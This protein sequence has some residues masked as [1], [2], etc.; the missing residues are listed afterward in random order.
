M[1]APDGP[2]MPV[3]WSSWTWNE[4]SV[5]DDVVPVAGGDGVEPDQLGADSRAGHAG[6]SGHWGYVAW[7]G[8][9][10][11]T[12]MASMVV[13]FPPS[14]LIIVAKSYFIRPSHEWSGS[15]GAP[16][17]SSSRRESS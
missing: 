3:N 7:S 5:Q 6:S 17:R 15:P 14:P 2:T 16:G 4:T 13:G 12:S 1:P 9:V 11:V 10:V 8:T